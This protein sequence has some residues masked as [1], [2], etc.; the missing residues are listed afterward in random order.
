MRVAR[1]ATPGIA[2]A[3]RLLQV[4]LQRHVEGAAAR[5][6]F[7]DQQRIQRVFG[8]GAVHR[9]W[10]GRA[11][12]VAAA[13]MSCGSLA[14]VAAQAATSTPQSTAVAVRAR[15]GIGGVR[16]DGDNMLIGCGLDRARGG[17]GSAGSAGFCTICP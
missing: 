1:A 2:R 15:R 12:V 14:G 16:N 13:S 8:E 3:R 11:A 5:R 6:E 9:L 10:R 17:G 4:V 7:G